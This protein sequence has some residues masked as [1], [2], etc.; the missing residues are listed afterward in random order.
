M[1]FVTLTH[2]LGAALRLNGSERYPNGFDRGSQPLKSARF[3]SFVGTV[4]RPVKKWTKRHS[5][6]PHP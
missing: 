4:S 1:Q 3:R 5:K 6:N 2:E